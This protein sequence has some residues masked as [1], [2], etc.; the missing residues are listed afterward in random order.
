MMK[1]KKLDL[2]T[3]AQ[4]HRAALSRAKK[5]KA[6]SL[7]VSPKTAEAYSRYSNLSYAEAVQEIFLITQA[8]LLPF[9]RSGDF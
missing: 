7:R 8:C 4:G 5:A 2:K 9:S 1:V 6:A 3:R